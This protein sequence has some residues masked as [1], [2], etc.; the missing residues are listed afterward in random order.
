MPDRDVDEEDPRPRQRLDEDAAEHE[1]DRAAADGDRRPHAH[2]LRPLCALRERR[3]DDRQRG[4]RDQRGAEALQAAEDDEHAGARREP[5]E[6]RGDGED[7]EADEED[8]LAPSEVARAPAEQE[9]AAEHQRVRVDDPL[10]VGLAEIPRSFWMDGSATFTI[11]A[12]RITMNCAMQTSTRTSQGLIR[13]SRAAGAADGE[14]RSWRFTLAMRAMVIVVTEMRLYDLRVTVERIE[15]R[16]VC[17]LE[18][19]DYFEVTESSRV[20]IPEGKHFCLF[21]MQSVLPLLP[22]KMRRLPDEDWL[23]QES[24][25]ACPD[26][27]ERLVMRIERIGERDARHRGADV[28]R[29]LGIGLRTDQAAGRV[30]GDRAARRGRRGR[31]P[32][33]LPRPSLPARD[34]AAPADG[35]RDGADPARAGGAQPVHAASVRDRRPDRDARLGLGRARV[36]RAREGRVARPSSGSRRIGRS[37]RCARPS[38]SSRAL[39]AGDTTGVA[40]ERFTL[41]PG[42]T[43]A[44]ARV[45][46]SVPLL[47]RHLGAGDGALGGTVADEVKIGGSAN[48][49]L[50]PVVRGWIDNP[51]VKIVV[52]CVTVVDD[53]GDWARERARASVEPYLDVV[54]ASRPDARARRAAAARALLHRRHARGGRRARHRALGGRRRPRRARHAAGPDAARRGRAD[55]RPRPPAARPLTRDP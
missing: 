32:L 20:R 12:S 53:D 34:R 7:D 22:A 55:L 44:Y 3:G 26:P 19:G 40:G 39:L 18:V 33:G 47:D 2:R 29:E 52:G 16:S 15:G 37:P 25:V 24:L 10:Q 35:A 4:R 42:T 1:P 8:L 21:A 30:R 11:V 9:E 41:A 46:D 43:L 50:V 49:D 48:P 36:S 17:G 23:E 5:V 14:R 28:A 54:A 13:W 45:R 38:P 6:Q 51:D 27:D 31:R